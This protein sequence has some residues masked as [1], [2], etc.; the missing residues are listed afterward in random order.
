MRLKY[1]IL[2]G[3]L[4]LASMLVVAGLWSIHALSSVGISV[5]ALLDDN[6]HSIRA[7]DAMQKALER[8]DSG[9]LLLMMGKWEEGREILASADAQFHE[10]FERAEGNL[11]I[12][13]EGE[14]IQDIAARYAV[15]ESLWERPIV[16]TD[17]EGDL[18][19]YFTEVHSAFL[20]VKNAVEELKR[21]NEA[22][23]YDTAS[24]VKSRAGRAVVPG[25]VATIS[26]LVFSVLFTYLVNRYVVLPIVRITRAAEDCARYRRPFQVEVETRDEIEELAAAVSK[27][28]N[29]A[30][31]S[32]EG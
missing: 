19:W 11:T 3:F 9:V 26:A 10:G 22:S 27:A 8:E 16:D 25:T 29:P 6:Y 23:L 14:H 21:L 1:K 28:C 30:T 2:A 31:D 12:P 7:A 5:Q 24:E 20:D 17:R 18:E 4:I 13:G 15:Y 32:G